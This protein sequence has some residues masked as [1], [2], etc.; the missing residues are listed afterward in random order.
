[1]DCLLCRLRNLLNFPGEFHP[2]LL[3]L[4]PGPGRRRLTTNGTRSVRSTLLPE[5]V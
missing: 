4:L 2:W 5:G 1:M 3:D